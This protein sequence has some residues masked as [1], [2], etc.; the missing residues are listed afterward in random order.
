MQ[1]K[2]RDMKYSVSSLS[3]ELEMR[4]PLRMLKDKNMRVSLLAERLE[5][6]IDKKLDSS[7]S[8]LE[9]YCARLCAQNP[10]LVL[11]KGYALIQNNENTVISSSRELSSGDDIKLV[12]ADGEVSA[13]VK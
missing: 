5:G 12:F 8:K 6:A 13:T 3:R 9:I 7:K 4:S 2:L 1:K 11:S 10:L